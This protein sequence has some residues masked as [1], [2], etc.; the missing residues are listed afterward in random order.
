MKQFLAGFA[1]CVAISTPALA[2]Q[3]DGPF[4]STFALVSYWSQ[5]STGGAA[6]QIYVNGHKVYDRYGFGP[7]FVKQ[8]FN[9]AD[10]SGIKA[11]CTSIFDGYTTVGGA[12]G[13][14]SSGLTVYL[15]GALYRS[16]SPFYNAHIKTCYGD[17]SYYGAMRYY[18]VESMYNGFGPAYPGNSCF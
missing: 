10:G 2:Q 5:Q 11:T 12:M 1:L 9:C 17:A 16:A 3:Q 4:S 7:A 6:T 13:T 8:Y 14:F 15:D 18:I